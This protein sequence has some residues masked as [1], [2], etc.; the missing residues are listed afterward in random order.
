MR[1]KDKKGLYLNGEFKTANYR[2][3]LALMYDNSNVNI[4]I[5]DF[6]YSGYSVIDGNGVQ[7]VFELSPSKFID[8][9]MNL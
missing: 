4:V 3:A 7:H 8:K 9:L 1:T 5:E 6:D 2:Q